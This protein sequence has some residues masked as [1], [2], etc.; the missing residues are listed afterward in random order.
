MA[1]IQVEPVIE[2]MKKLGLF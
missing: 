1:E 2:Q